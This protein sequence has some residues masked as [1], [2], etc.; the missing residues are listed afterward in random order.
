MTSDYRALFTDL[1][2]DQV[3]D[4]LPISEVAFEDYIGKAGTLNG[5]LNAPDQLTADRIRTA[6][7]P[8][9]TALWLERDRVI[10]WAGI[11]WTTTV[12][13]ANRATPAKAEIQAG[14]FDTYLDHRLLTDDLTA[15]D[16]DQF[17]IARR[18]ID[19]AQDKTGGNIGIRLGS[20]ASGVTRTRRYS[21]YDLPKIRELL[22]KLAGVNNGFEWRIRC[23]RDQAGNRR[24]DLQLGHPHITTSGS[25][26]TVLDYPGAVISYSFPYDA[27]TKATHWRSRGATTGTGTN[28]RPLVSTPY[29]IIGATDA[30]WPRL[31]GTSDYTTITTKAALDAHARGDLTAAWTRRAVP[32]LA[33][34][35]DAARLTPSILGAT[36]RLRIADVWATGFAERYRVIGLRIRAPERGQGET[37]ELLL[38]DTEPADSGDDTDNV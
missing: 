35:L 22:D 37:A 20:G 3:I 8:G 13:S 18:L 11:I 38:D 5:T 26:E 25:A 32:E 36:I 17:T 2:S 15:T 1:R 29:Y 24:K 27:T 6:T 33:V 9:R 7:V 4:A 14:T 31:D 16:E 30:G 28:A 10:W 34:N 12:R 21:R 19:Y 23:Y